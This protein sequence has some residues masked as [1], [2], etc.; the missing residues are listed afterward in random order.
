MKKGR[1]SRTVRVA[2]ELEA[3]RPAAKEHALQ[4]L[5]ERKAEQALDF[6]KKIKENR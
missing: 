6:A 3:R 1:V 2:A 4:G 5:R